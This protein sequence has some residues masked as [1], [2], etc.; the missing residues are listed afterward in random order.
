[1]FSNI[2]QLGKYFNYRLLNFTNI[3]HKQ[4]RR[5]IVAVLNYNCM[6]CRET[7]V[8]STLQQTNPSDWN[9]QCTSVHSYY[10]YLVWIR[11]P[12]TVICLYGLFVINCPRGIYPQSCVVK[13]LYCGTNFLQAGMSVF[14]FERNPFHPSVGELRI[15][16]KMILGDTWIVTTT[17]HNI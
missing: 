1:M 5:N 8:M 2:L 15:K 6:N 11:W 12:C 10:E 4:G 17:T 13:E 3:K 16:P 14:H 9:K 7:N